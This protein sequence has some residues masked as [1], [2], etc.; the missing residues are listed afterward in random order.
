MVLRC[1]GLLVEEKKKNDGRLVLNGREEIER[2]V[3]SGIYLFLFREE[4][5]WFII[6]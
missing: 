4:F 2:L 5:L 1:G 6:N 3:S